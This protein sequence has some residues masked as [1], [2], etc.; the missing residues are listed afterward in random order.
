MS[1]MKS[2]FDGWTKQ[3]IGVASDSAGRKCAGE[4]VL[5]AEV[6][7]RI[8][9]YID[10]PNFAMQIIINANDRKKWNPAKFREIDLLSQG[11]EEIYP[12]TNSHS[13]TAPALQEDELCLV[14]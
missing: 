14:K 10:A 13:R 11:L 7:V 12:T 4:C 2:V 6:L 3:A 1:E 9:R 8:G 5:D